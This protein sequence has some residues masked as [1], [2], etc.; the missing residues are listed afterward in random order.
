MG[1]RRKNRIR[2]TA[3]PAQVKITEPVPSFEKSV[4]LFLNNEKAKNR[5]KRTLEWHRENF[6]AVKKAF[7]QQGTDLD[8]EKITS[9]TVTNHLVLYFIDKGIKPQTIN[10]RLRSLRQLFNFLVEQ[11]FLIEN[12]VLKVERL[13][14]PERLVIS[15]SDDQVHRLLRMP[16]KKTFTGLRDFTIMCLLLDTGVRLSEAASLQISD[17][18]FAENHIKIMGKGSR[19]RTVPLQG[20]L[21]TVLRKYLQHRGDLEHDY[22]F[23]TIDDNPI[24]NRSIQERFELYADKAG[25]GHIRT[26]PHI[27]RH[28]FA[29]LYVVNQGDAFSLKAILGHKSWEMVHHY[30]TLFGADIQTKHMKASPLKNLDSIF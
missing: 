7:S 18:H 8:L 30:V 6:H 1:R 21:K 24:Q 16:D 29:R 27:W 28:T 5:K 17:L 11:G 14:T 25:L 10:M 4:S 3:E 22:V 2:Q 9:K 15:L 23:V 26:S 20:R 13:K 19:E 12:P